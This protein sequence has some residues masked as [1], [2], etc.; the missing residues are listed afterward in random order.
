MKQPLQVVTIAPSLGGVPALKH[1]RAAHATWIDEVESYLMPIVAPEATFWQR[2]TAVRYIADQFQ[3]Q[4]R[5][6][7]TLLEGLRGVLPAAVVD[8]LLQHGDHIERLQRE[9]D[10]VGRR[11]GTARR[12]SGAAGKLLDVIRCWCADL[13]TAVQ[14]MRGDRLPTELQGP[15]LPTPSDP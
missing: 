4:Y 10:Q 13:E 9:L 14:G 6:E 11:R 15:P 8:S 3:S 7:R 2:W 12:V 1:V 5:R